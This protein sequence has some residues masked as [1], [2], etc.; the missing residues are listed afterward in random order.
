M[1]I[2]DF[3]ENSSVYSVAAIFPA[4]S[5]QL[6]SNCQTDIT[7]PRLKSLNNPIPSML[8]W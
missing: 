2:Q 8:F 1:E 6:V 5:M 3:Q 7:S 4:I